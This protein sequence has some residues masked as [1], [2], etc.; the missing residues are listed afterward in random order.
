MEGDPSLERVGKG[1][2]GVEHV[3][4]RK[5]KAVSRFTCLKKA[6]SRKT[7]DSNKII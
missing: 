7:I 1:G 4:Q 5:K 3:S 6:I 2:G